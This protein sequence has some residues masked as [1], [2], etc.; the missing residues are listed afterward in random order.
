MG[1]WGQLDPAKRDQTV[2]GAKLADINK[3]LD[4]IEKMIPAKAYLAGAKP[5]LADVYA[6]PALF[7]LHK[8]LPM[9]GADPLGSRK[10]LTKYCAK[11]KKD[12]VISGVMTE[13]E[14]ALTAWQASQARAA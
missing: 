14:E 7:Y 5:S 10:K 3:Y 9:F 8:F 6:V 12:K 11:A 4:I 2:V 13:M 1:L